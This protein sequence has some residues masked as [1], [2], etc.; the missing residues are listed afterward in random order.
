MSIED[1]ALLAEADLEGQDEPI[2]FVLEVYNDEVASVA[3][4]GRRSG[5]AVVAKTREGKTILRSQGLEF[6]SVD[7]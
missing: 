5:A 1:G 2:R 4:L 6:V 7:R 3:G